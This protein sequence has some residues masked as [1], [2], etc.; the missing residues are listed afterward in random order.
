MKI[1]VG[2]L[3]FKEESF[4]LVKRQLSKIHYRFFPPENRT[5]MYATNYIKFTF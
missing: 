4:R 1:N 2:R 5:K 3:K